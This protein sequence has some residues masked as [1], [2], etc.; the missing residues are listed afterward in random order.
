MIQLMDTDH[1]S[2]FTRATA[3]GAAIRRRLRA[4]AP[5]DYGTTVV[6]YEEQCRGWLDK[7]HQ[8]QTPE[9]RVEAYSLLKEN[10]DVF[11]RIAVVSYTAEAD[12]EFVTL[13]K[14]LKNKVGTKDLRIAAIAIVN[15]ATLLTRNTRD[16][17]RVPGL[18]FDDWTV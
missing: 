18:L 17:A 4:V 8:A 12:A 11:S 10:L 7:I 2:L 5:D 6:T 15:E 3:E 9:A 13:K 16:F 14:I 1:F